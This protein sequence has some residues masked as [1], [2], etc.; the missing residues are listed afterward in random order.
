VAGRKVEARFLDTEAKP[1]L[2]RRQGEKLALEGFKLLTGTVASGE[3]LAM[4]PMLARWDA[5]Y[6]STI[7][8]ANQITGAACTARMFRVNRLDASDGAVVTPWLAERKETKWAIMAADIAWGRDSGASFIKAAK[9]NNREIVTENY[10]P[11]GSNDFAPY[12]QKIKD[13]GAQALWVALAGRDAINF[14][15][16]AKQFG[17]FDTV[18]T[19]GVSF[20]TD[21]TV[22]TLGDASKGIW[23]IINYSATL[24]TPANK[25]FVADW[26]KKY[27]G[28][29][30]TN[31]EGETYIGMQVILQAVAKAG[32]A[33][34]ADVAK[35]MEGTTFDTILGKQL[36]RKEDHQLV[37]PNFFGFVGDAGGK[38]KPIITMSVPAEVATPPADAACKL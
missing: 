3:G 34:P 18:F 5:I 16:Q 14:A 9:A 28:T 17:L 13:S 25:K 27:P 31:F 33:K 35:A 11:F 30:P 20:V 19:A 22:K 23:G 36:M 1:D 7:N 29:E 6:V 21:N 26:A 2:A 4:G 38:L 32:S 8:K 15:T 10:S 37:G 24:D 12:I